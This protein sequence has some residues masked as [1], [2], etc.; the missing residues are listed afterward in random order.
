MNAD[1]HVVPHEGGW[2][3]GIEPYRQWVRGNMKRVVPVPEHVRRGLGFRTVWMCRAWPQDPQDA[4]FRFGDLPKLAQE[5]K[6]HGLDEMVLWFTHHAFE[7]PL[8]PFFEHLGGENEFVKA[9]AECKRLGVNVLPFISVC[10]AKE[11]TAAR[12]GLKVGNSGWTY[13]PELLPRFNPPYAGAYRCAQIPT[14]NPLWQKEVLASCKR[15]VDMGIPSLCW[16]TY[17]LELPE[18]SVPAV[19]RQIRA[20]SRA[21]DPQSSFAAE[22]SASIE[23]S[24]DYLDYTWNWS[25][26]R[27]LSAATAVFPSTRLNLNVDDS[28]EDAKTAFV[29]NAYVNT[30]PRRPDD[31]NGSD[32]IANHA[33]LSGA[34]TLSFGGAP[35][36]SPNVIS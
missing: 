19:T 28:A 27:D 1:Q 35:G 33:E 4:L 13:H 31:I 16:D 18:L 14:R 7:L 2:A 25:A 23:V 8:P 12:Y 20:Y 22:E 9:V 11:K 17:F 29:Q 3:K 24:G 21:R 5:A 32:W 30:Q 6:E 10:L 26:R 15:L 34:L 36:A